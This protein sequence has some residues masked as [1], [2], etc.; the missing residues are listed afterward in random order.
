M[1]S[2]KSISLVIYTNKLPKPYDTTEKFNDYLLNLISTNLVNLESL[3]YRTSFWAHPDAKSHASLRHVNK[4][5][6]LQA[7]VLGPLQK[8]P[9]DPPYISYFDDIASKLTKLV[10]NCNNCWKPADFKEFAK[11]TSLKS[12]TINAEHEAMLLIPMSSLL[13]LDY[14]YLEMATITQA[15]LDRLGDLPSLETLSISPASASPADVNFSVLPPTLT[16][17]QI[18][19]ASVEFTNQSIA[20]IGKLTSLKVRSLL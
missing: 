20:S 5:T 10:F 19:S 17:L 15:T 1:T 4:L 9:D 18:F 2:L 3:E 11:F 12:L 8:Q 6:K 13:Q 7:L 14:V 16:A